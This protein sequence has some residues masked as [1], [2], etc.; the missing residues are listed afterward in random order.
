MGDERKLI[1]EMVAEGK[2]TPE[3]ALKLLEAIDDGERTAE[4][5]AKEHIRSSSD[6]DG[7][8]RLRDLGASIEQA[9]KE[10]LR[11]LEDLLDN[12]ENQIDRKM[13]ETNTRQIWKQAE[14]RIRRAAE[15]AISQAER[16]EQRAAAAAEA[17][18]R[19]A[20]KAA[21][22]AEAVAR[23]FGGTGAARRVPGEGKAAVE[24]IDRLCITGGPQNRLVADSRSGDINVDFCDDSEIQ[25]EAI[26]RA[27]GRDKEQAQRRLDGFRVALQQDGRDI[28][29]TTSDG[30]EGAEAGSHVRVDY[31]IRVPHGADLSL[32]TQVG[33]L[34]VTAAERIGRWDLTAR[35]GDVDMQV[36]TGAGFTYTLKTRDGEI[37]VSLD[38]H[39]VTQDEAVSGSVGDGSGDIRAFADMGD[40]ELHY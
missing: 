14:E 21:R 6:G 10:G 20:A 36:G 38:T 7:R 16:A 5:A 37:A 17:A 15:Q 11:G 28:I 23:R 18:A 33:D 29:L 8:G 22:R 34:E 39:R 40:I 1:L 2:I 31:R 27:W 26:C 35:V 19:K 13:N 32:T 25:V 9:V 12:L 24:R 3:E 4:E 30:A